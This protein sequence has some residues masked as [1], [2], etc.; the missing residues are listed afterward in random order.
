[1]D[2]EFA[3]FEAL[4]EQ[5]NAFDNK[6]LLDAIGEA[7]CTFPAATCAEFDA[8]AP[9]EA[10][11]IYGLRT[12]EGI[13]FETQCMLAEDFGSTGHPFTRFWHY[14]GGQGG[15]WPES[16]D[17]LQD[18]YGGCDS[19]HYCFGRLPLWLSEVGTE[20]I[21]DGGMVAN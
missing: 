3:A 20:L 8:L 6:D 16:R 14:S 10:S 12:A 7:K 17:V 2:D 9:I 11:G 19:S 1:M 21:I 4:N 5:C 15:T 18:E 13:S